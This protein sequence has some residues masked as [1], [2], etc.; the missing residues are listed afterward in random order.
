MDPYPRTP[1]PVLPFGVYYVEI[2]SG[3]YTTIGRCSD[4]TVK[5]YSGSGAVPVPP[6]LPGRS[7]VD[8]EF[9][10]N[11]AAARVGP[12]ST[13]IGYGHGCS[14]S[15]PASRLVPMDTPRLGKTFQANLLDLPTDA[16][17]MLFGWARTTPQPLDPLGMPG[18][19]SHI[20][21]D[22]AYFLAGAHG[23]AKYFLPIPNLP[24]LVGLRFHNQAVVFDPGANNPL[25][26]VVSDAAEG[27]IGHW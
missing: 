21:L 26:A 5:S 14:G 23:W 9:S 6:L 10:G 13:Y 8:V 12:T 15:R 11:Q 22:G 1:W 4:G 17:V 27:V 16:A 20:T 24:G 3:T 25:R 2:A 19:A 7:Y 18:C